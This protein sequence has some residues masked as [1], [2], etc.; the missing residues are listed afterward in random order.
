MGTGDGSRG[1]RG[2]GCSHDLLEEE[3]LGI[4]V[5]SGV[6]RIRIGHRSEGIGRSP[7]IIGA[8]PESDSSDPQFIRLGRGCGGAGT[9]SGA[10]SAGSYRPVQRAG[11]LNSAVLRDDRSSPQ[12]CRCREAN[13]RH[14]SRSCRDVGAKPDFGRRSCS[15]II[16]HPLG[17]R[18]LCPSDSGL[19]NAADSASGVATRCDHG[20]QRISARGR[21][22][23][24]SEGGRRV[25]SRIAGCGIADPGRCDKTRKET[26]WTGI[27]ARQH[28]GSSQ[29]EIIATHLVADGQTCRRCK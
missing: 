24:D 14:C 5:G 3:R 29:D 15:R 2:A 1:D 10:V 20:D 16:V 28:C 23:A 12:C 19:R 27:L 21:R 6:G 13:R 17:S 18:G 7:E 8:V 26:L 4:G 11:Q 25:C 9:R 22:H